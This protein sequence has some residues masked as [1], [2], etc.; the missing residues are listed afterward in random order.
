MNKLNRKAKSSLITKSSISNLKTKTY[1]F[2]PTPYPTSTYKLA[3]TES[4]SVSRA[5]KLSKKENTQH[6][7]QESQPILE[8]ESVGHFSTA[9][10]SNWH[11]TVSTKSDIYNV[12]TEII[13]MHKFQKITSS[14]IPSNPL[15]DETK[16]DRKH[17]IPINQQIMDSSAVREALK[18]ANETPGTKLN[19]ATIRHQSKIA[20]LPRWYIAPN[21]HPSI[22][23]KK[24]FTRKGATKNSDTS[25]HRASMKKY[26]N[27]FYRW[28]T[29]SQIDHDKA[30]NESFQEKST[31]E[32]SNTVPLNMI[33]SN[34]RKE[35]IDSA[36]EDDMLE[37][38]LD[39]LLH[40]TM[41]LQN[42]TE[43]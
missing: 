43:K 7:F 9:P 29:R 16:I 20:T 19:T 6:D 18:L 25:S 32:K 8:K 36:S 27:N 12:Y 41:K 11:E 35:I 14:Q 26:K 13:P 10:T 2:S 5:N 37:I 4:A 34:T 3:S 40:E 22:S 17:A 30:E 24:T 31:H 28:D 15:N 38:I 39:H 33:T 23:E 1:R 21:K 42:S